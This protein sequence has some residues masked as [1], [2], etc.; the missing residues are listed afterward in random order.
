MNLSLQKYNQ[1]R[2]STS[3]EDGDFRKEVT[4]SQQLNRTIDSK[5]RDIMELQRQI[6]GLPLLQNQYQQLQR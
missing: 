6:A 5:N 4:R 3:V 1:G 2:T